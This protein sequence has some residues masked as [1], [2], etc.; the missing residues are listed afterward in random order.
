MEIEDWYVEYSVRLPSGDV[1]T[2][3]CH[4]PLD[5]FY[6]HYLKSLKALREYEHKSDE[7][8][9]IQHVWSDNSIS[10]LMVG[11]K[12]LPQMKLDPPGVLVVSKEYPITLIAPDGTRYVRSG[13]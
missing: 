13:F 9:P 10:L 4:W 12:R 5:A 8:N 2:G 3:N 11:T 7:V 6:H 1:L